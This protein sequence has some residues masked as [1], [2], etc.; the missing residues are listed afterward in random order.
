MLNKQNI[1]YKEEKKRTEKVPLSGYLHTGKLRA[2]SSSLGPIV[3][4]HS[5][6]IIHSSQTNDNRLHKV[7]EEIKM[8]QSYKIL[9]GSL[10]GY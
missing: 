1:W 8:W 4:H 3:I 10:K 5:K 9:R 7:L 2:D 6:D